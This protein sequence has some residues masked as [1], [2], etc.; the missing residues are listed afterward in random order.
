MYLHLLT[1]SLSEP[2]FGPAKGPTT[3]DDGLKGPGSRGAT[4]NSAPAVAASGAKG[5]SLIFL[6]Y[7]TS[8]H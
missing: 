8:T 1:L 2:L 7:T 3:K 6:V 4:A 5:M